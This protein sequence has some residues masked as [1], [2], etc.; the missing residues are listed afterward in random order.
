MTVA[1][2]RPARVDEA[3]HVR[4]KTLELSGARLRLDQAICREADVL[5]K[6]EVEVCIVTSDG[7]PR[8]V[9][10]MVRKKLQRFV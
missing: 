2:N 5:V 7:K 10:E 3:L 9:P 8:R 4:T 1:F 6:A